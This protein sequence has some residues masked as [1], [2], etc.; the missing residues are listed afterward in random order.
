MLCKIRKMKGIAFK[1]SH[2]GPFIK[3]S[4][5]TLVASKLI[6][7]YLE[8]ACATGQSQRCL[9]KT[10]VQRY[11]WTIQKKNSHTHH[12]GL[13]SRTREYLRRRVTRKF[14][15][16]IVGFLCLRGRIL[17]DLLSSVN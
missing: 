17:G 12:F 8:S 7:G 10:K 9:S 1:I 13:L 5:F 16:G 11:G 4:M 2:A 15:D 14:G 3:E 6:C